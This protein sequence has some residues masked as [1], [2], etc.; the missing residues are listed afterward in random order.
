MYLSL[1]CG[2]WKT[3]CRPALGAWRRAKT[4]TKAP[5]SAPPTVQLGGR[6]VLRLSDVPEEPEPTWKATM[7]STFLPEPGPLPSSTCAKLPRPKCAWHHL[8][9][10]H[11]IGQIVA[12]STKTDQ[13]RRDEETPKSHHTQHSELTKVTMSS[14]HNDK[15]ECARWARGQVVRLEQTK[16]ATLATV[17]HLFGTHQCSFLLNFQTDRPHVYSA[18][19]AI[20]VL[21]LQQGTRLAQQMTLEIFAIVSQCRQ[22]G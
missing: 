21:D 18:V 5:P 20:R 3:P 10:H 12:V 1:Y 14:K 22:C 15:P 2:R 9:V 19:L 16:P 7:M 4:P 17:R 8:G 6:P 11:R 13:S